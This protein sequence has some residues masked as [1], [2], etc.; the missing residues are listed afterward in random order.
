[1]TLKHYLFG[2]FSFLHIISFSQQLNPEDKPELEKFISAFASNDLGEILPYI[3]YPL[4]RQY[5]LPDIKNDVEFIYAFNTIFDDSLIHEITNSNID[6]DWSRV[7]WR[8]IM[9]HHGSIWLTEDYKLKAVN[10]QSTQESLIRN[11]IIDRDR[12]LIHESLN[13]YSYPVLVVH[14]KLHLIRIDEMADYTYRYAV[15]PMT[16]N[17]S[18]KPDLIIE[19]GELEYQGSGGNHVYNFVNGDY[20]YE[21]YIDVLGESDSPEAHLTVK[22]I[23]KEI[24]NS[25]GTIIRN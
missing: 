18:N 15:W 14:S 21:L 1:M 25:R 16:S 4:R 6:E 23:G 20:T 24:M 17:F 12:A 2:L 13:N 19:N 8:G 22:K 5:P 3:T 9:L 7:G 10:A 11:A